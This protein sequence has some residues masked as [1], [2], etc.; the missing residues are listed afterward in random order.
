MLKMD[1]INQ[2]E[3]QVK[4]SVQAL[5]AR[6]SNLEDLGTHL[7]VCLACCVIA[8]CAPMAYFIL[9]LCYVSLMQLHLNT[10]ISYA[11]CI[12]LKILPTINRTKFHIYMH[13][14]SV[15]IE[16]YRVLIL[17]LSN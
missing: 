7:Y 1:D 10:L 6:L 4:M 11:G 16:T 15:H 9:L 17:Y 2:K 3:T 13:M 12:K 5:E 8:G 14:L